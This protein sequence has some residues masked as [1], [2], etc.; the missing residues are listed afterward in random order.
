M[1]K[2][3]TLMAMIA[4]CGTSVFATISTNSSGQIIDT[5]TNFLG[6]E[7]VTVIGYASTTVSPYTLTPSAA[8]E[9]LDVTGGG[10]YIIDPVETAGALATVTLSAARQGEV[11]RL[12]ILPAT[13]SFIITEGDTAQLSGGSITQT[14]AGTND[15]IEL[16][17]VGTTWREA[18]STAL[19]E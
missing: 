15:L 6:D 11:L 3:I 18:N 8:D 5:Q 14:G 9:V 17:G 12:V 10:T 13:N 16:W 2:V 4:V 1:K 19:A 7:I